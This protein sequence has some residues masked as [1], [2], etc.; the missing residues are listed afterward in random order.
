MRHN[1]MAFMP[2]EITVEDGLRMLGEIETKVKATPGA[3]QV[4]GDR[5][6][7][8]DDDRPFFGTH[9][10]RQDLVSIGCINC[11]E[12]LT[13]ENARGECPGD[14]HGNPVVRPQMLVGALGSV[15]RNDPCPCGSGKKFKKCHGAS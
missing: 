2:Y 6:P 13:A 7:A 9:N 11:E 3:H 12:P 14:P 10:L 5:P 1:W 4:A 8:L 15:G